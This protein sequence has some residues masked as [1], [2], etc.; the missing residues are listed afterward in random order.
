MDLKKVIKEVVEH[1][2]GQENLRSVVHCATRLRLEL[3]DEKKYNKEKLED[4]EGVKGVF[5]N[6]GQLQLIFGSGLVQQVYAAYNEVFKGA[7][8]NS[9][10]DSSETVKKTK[11][12]PLQ[13]F[14]K[15][16]SDIF[17]PIIPAI[18][19]GGLL[20]GINNVLTAKDLFYTGKSVIEANPGIAGLADMVNV[21]A[22]APFVFLPVL[23]GFSATKRFGGNPYLGAALAMLMVHPDVM[24]FYTF[25][26]LDPSTNQL[27]AP[28]LDIVNQSG[29][30][31]EGL[32]RVTTLGYWD[33]FGFKIAKVGYQGTVL[34]ILAAAWLLAT[35]EK[36]LRR[37]TPSWLDNLTTPL[38]SLFVTG[39]VTFAWMGPVLREAGTLLGQGLQWLYMQGG[40]VGAGIFGLFYA[41]IVIT[42]LH[43]SFSAIETQLLAATGLTFIFPIASMSNVAQGAAVL[44]VL[45]FAKNTKMKSISSASGISALLGITEPAMFGVNL[46]LRYP[47]YGAIAGSAVGSAWIG[48]NKVFAS[49]LGAAGLPGFLSIPANHWSTFGIGLALSF[50]VSFSVTAYFFKTKKELV[51]AS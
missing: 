2:G 1:S 6:N 4:I 19:A 25:G 5:F 36:F 35:I 33:V 46:R 3:N 40:F 47:F 12:N 50:I 13:R 22:N 49:A 29:Q 18:V 17:V 48:L 37:V 41:P 31:V 45:V 39:F 23:I 8:S 21:F 26:K 11:G 24:N 28:A 32:Q 34:P 27:L 51:N 7:A 14:V 43:Q 44:A 10:E 30:A 9:E 38:V 15:M 20:M 16:L 42:G